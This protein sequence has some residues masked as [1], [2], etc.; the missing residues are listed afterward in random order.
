MHRA[1]NTAEHSW[2]ECPWPGNENAHFSSDWNTSTYLS[3][4]R[5]A[6][7][8]ARC[9]SHANEFGAGFVGMTQNMRKHPRKTCRVSIL[10]GV[11]MRTDG[12]DEATATRDNGNTTTSESFEGHDPERLFPPRWDDKETLLIQGLSDHRR[13]EGAR[14]LHLAIESPCCNH[15]FELRLFLAVSDNCRAAG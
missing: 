9:A 1:L 11:S 8:F 12:F 10:E 13:S 6:V 3:A 7:K 2:G 5:R 4:T 14:E 15:T